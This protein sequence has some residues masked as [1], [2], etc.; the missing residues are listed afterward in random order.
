MRFRFFYSPHMVHQNGRE[1]W[2]KIFVLSEGGLLY[3][4]YLNWM[5]LST[6]KK[7]VEFDKFDPSRFKWADYQPLSEISKEEALAVSLIQQGNWVSRYLD[8]F[9]G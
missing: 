4:E 5:N 7:E 3:C 8:S 6:F 9:S 2:P 1:T